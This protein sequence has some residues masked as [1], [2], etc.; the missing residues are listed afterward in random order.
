VKPKGWYFFYRIFVFISGL[1][2]VLA[3]AAV[4]FLIYLIF[5]PK[6]GGIGQQNRAGAQGFN[7]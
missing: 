5:Q 3:I 4:G 1:S 6:V 7:Q 2:L